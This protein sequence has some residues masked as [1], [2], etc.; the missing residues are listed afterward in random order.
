MFLFLRQLRRRSNVRVRLHTHLQQEA[1]RLAAHG[2]RQLRGRRQVHGV[3]P[4]LGVRW[5]DAYVLQ[6]AERRAALLMSAA[7]RSRT[8]RRRRGRRAAP[9]VAP[10]RQLCISAVHQGSVCSAPL[11]GRPPILLGK[12]WRSRS[13]ARAGGSAKP[14][15]HCGERGAPRGVGRLVARCWTTYAAAGTPLGLLP[16]GAPLHTSRSSGSSS[17]YSSTRAMV[18]SFGLVDC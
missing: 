3:E 11:T 10:R 12:R 18:A 1:Q 15:F 2:A 16:A 17:E 5:G 7:R 6:S 13:V 14:R 8:A 9:A 4:G